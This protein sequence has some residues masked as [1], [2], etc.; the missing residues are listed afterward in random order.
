MTAVVRPSASREKATAIWMPT[1]SPDS[2]AN[3]TTG[4]ERTTVWQ[5]RRQKGPF[6][7]FR[8]CLGIFK[9]CFGKAPLR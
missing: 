5:V 6:Y 2:S 4:G 7:M 9:G 3:M 1:V 8:G